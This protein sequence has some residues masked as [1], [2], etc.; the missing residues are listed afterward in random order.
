MINYCSNYISQHGLSFNASKTVCTTL[1]P[2]YFINTP[3]WTMNNVQLKNEN[4]VN[5]LGAVISNEKLL[6][7]DNRTSKCRKAFYY[8]QGAGLCKGGVNPSVVRH[9]WTTAISPILTYSL[10]CMDVTQ[11]SMKDIECLQSKLLKASLGLPKYCRNSPL[12]SA[13]NIPRVKDLMDIQSLNLARTNI[14]SSSRSKHF[15]AHL[16]RCH[17]S[18][19]INMSRHNDLI[20]RVKKICNERQYSF[21]KFV[22]NDS[23][24]LHVKNSIKYNNVVN[25]GVVDSLKL[26]LNDF[27]CDNVEIA[28]LLLSPF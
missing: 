27:N 13:L 24:R 21:S 9:I 23:Y 16:I 15:Y 6:N 14:L 17:S 7:I 8:L 10:S 2:S 20:S 11:T 1:G 28:R 5:Y 18:N 26:L 19:N 4:Y 3:S 22:L 12:L 25:D